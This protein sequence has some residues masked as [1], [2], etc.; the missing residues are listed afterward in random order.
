MK[1]I[2]FYSTVHKVS[3]ILFRLFGF[4]PASIDNLATQSFMIFW[5]YIILFLIIIHFMISMRFQ[6]F[7]LSQSPVGNVNDFLRLCSGSIAYFVIIIESLCGIRKYKVITKSI[8]LLDEELETLGRDFKKFEFEFVK[9]FAINFLIFFILHF[10]SEIYLVVTYDWIIYT[11]V[12][13]MIPGLA[14]RL[15]HIQY[16]FYI[17]L[18]RSKLRI[19]QN[20]L[21]E[22]FN[23]NYDSKRLIKRLQTLKDVH[24]ILWRMTYD[25]NEMF[26]WSITAT[27]IRNFLQIG[28]D[29]YWAFIHYNTQP[30]DSQTSI[31]I[32]PSAILLVIML[33]EA[34]E[35]QTESAK[36]AILL[37]S[38]KRLKTNNDDPLHNMVSC[39]LCN[40]N[41]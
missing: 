6:E 40:S 29:S 27:L 19:I 16:I 14:F 36:I 15:R 26:A 5:S 35:I 22:S 34:N 30:P 38:K 23:A 1:A 12:A 41:Y 9:I 17:L 33:S 25:I 31:N 32:A 28:C 10:G 2:K 4:I 7:L 21:T 24:G 8:K 3:F 13:N 11:I 20:E 39:C 18:I 37:H